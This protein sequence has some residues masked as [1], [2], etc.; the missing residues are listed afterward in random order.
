LDRLCANNFDAHRRPRITAVFGEIPAWFGC[1]FGYSGEGQPVR[2]APGWSLT[3]HRLP[4][5]AHWRPES[6]GWRHFDAHP[7]APAAPFTG[8]A[9]PALS[10]A[11]PKSTVLP[12]RHGIGPRYFPLPPGKKKASLTQLS[13]AEMHPLRN[14]PRLSTPFIGANHFC[15]SRLLAHARNRE[16]RGKI[17]SC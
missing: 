13:F 11:R 9:G 10:T 2:S 7:C 17:W 6:L 16:K 12:S 3:D 15:L 8:S 1:G 5:H 14:L 4:A